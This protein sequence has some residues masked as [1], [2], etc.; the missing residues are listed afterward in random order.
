MKLS[1]RAMAGWAIGVF[2][3]IGL[4]LLLIG[5]LRGNDTDSQQEPPVNQTPDS[6]A[7]L[8]AGPA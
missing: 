6:A 2:I 4:V 1:S 7:L 8:P 5:A 3:L